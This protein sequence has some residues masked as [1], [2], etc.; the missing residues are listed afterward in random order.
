MIIT[1]P[2]INL[3]SMT[4]PTYAKKKTVMS[5]WPSFLAKKKKKG[6]EL[7]RCLTT[8]KGPGKGHE[9]VPK[10]IGMTNETPPAGHQQSLPCCC[11]NGLQSCRES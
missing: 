9:E 6:R 2:D 10:V 7:L 4:S 3:L 11:G 8:R 1:Q 5:A